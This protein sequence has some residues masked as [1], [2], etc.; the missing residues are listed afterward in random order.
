MGNVIKSVKVNG[1]S[2]GIDYDALENRPV[3]K[4]VTLG[5]YLVEETTVSFTVS[6]D[7]P[8]LTATIEIQGAIED[9]DRFIVTV[10]DTEYE[11]D[12]FVFESTRG[13]SYMIGNAGVRVQW[14]SEGIGEFSIVNTK[15]RRIELEDG[16]HQVSI[17]HYSK[18]VRR[19]DREFF[20][21]FNLD[22][23]SYVR[24]EKNLSVTDLAGSILR[25]EDYICLLITGASSLQ[26]GFINVMNAGNPF[27]YNPASGYLLA[28]ESED[29]IFD[30]SETVEDS[31]SYTRTSFVGSALVYGDGEPVSICS[32]SK[33]GS[34]W[35]LEAAESY[36]RDADGNI[37]HD[38]TS[39]PIQFDTSTGGFIL[40]G[41]P[42]QEQA[43]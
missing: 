32:A 28:V 43:I 40:S 2:Y 15:T 41:D 4:N 29:N 3:Y 14:G 12:S 11:C 37:V 10:D 42:T 1:T 33:S 17:R 31:D 9:G 26:N 22:E 25:Q 24:I 23:S 39:E 19:L 36:L 7:F 6:E 27:T 30:A 5:D 8:G 34:F 21:L 18:D 16:D 35:S 13:Q 20:G 38:F